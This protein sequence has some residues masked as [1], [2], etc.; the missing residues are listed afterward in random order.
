MDINKKLEEILRS[1]DDISGFAKKHENDET[2]FRFRYQNRL[3][4]EA[5]SAD[6]PN[7]FDSVVLTFSMP[8]KAKL[9]KGGKIDKAFE[10]W[11]TE[12]AEAFN[13]SGVGAITGSHSEFG[14]FMSVS[15]D[16]LSAIPALITKFEPEFLPLIKDFIK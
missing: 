2:V 10:Q 6:N 8:V 13:E 7:E 12:V 15:L 1:I 14:Y 16:L 9:F 3:D 4:V 11:G 5:S